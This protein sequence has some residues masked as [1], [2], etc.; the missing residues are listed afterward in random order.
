MTLGEIVTA[1]FRAAAIFE[2]YGLD[3]CCRGNRSLDQS[4]RDAG[5]RTETV[6]E[7]LEA[8]EAAPAGDTPAFNE[9]RLPVLVD[10][11]VTKH[12]AYVRDALPVL[13]A[14]STKIAK[15]HGKR[16]PELVRV[17]HLVEHVAAEMTSHMMKEEHVLFPYILELASAAERGGP[18]PF[19]PFGTVAN[20]I[21]MM[22]VEHEAA[23]N[24]MFEIRELTDGYEV[25]AD[26]CTT[27]AV[28]L[29]E[30]DAFER[31]LHA[32]VHLENNI[33]FPRAAALEPV[34]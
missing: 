18:A 20:P 2:R 23:G 25:P 30:L 34:K 12:H 24:A 26:G 7:E 10:Y 33:L 9:W 27:Y 22:E 5:V 3:F 8:L 31:D 19:A 6:S 1:D 32:H 13:L 29:R 4:C 11:I 16:H 28:C 14:H 15:V 21:H 17:A